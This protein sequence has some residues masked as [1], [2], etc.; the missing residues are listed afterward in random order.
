MRSI[1]YFIYIF[2][3]LTSCKR[4]HHEE[5]ISD[6]EI[7]SS[8]ENHSNTKNKNEKVEIIGLL[9]HRFGDLKY[10]STNISASLFE[11]HLKYLKENEFRVIT[12]GE[13]MNILFS[14]QSVGRYVVITID[15]GFKSFKE[16][17]YPLLKKY[18]FQATLFINTETVGSG[19]YLNWEDLALISSNGIEIG[20][21]THSHGYFLNMDQSE[22]YSNFKND[23]TL[24]Q[25]ILDERLNVQPV[26][27]AYPFGEYDSIMKQEIA[28]LGFLG[29][30]AQNSGVISHYSDS[31]ALPRFPMTEQYGNMASFIEKLSLKPLPV[32]FED[33]QTTTPIENPPILRIQLKKG[34]YNIDQMQCFIQGGSCE[35]LTIN[36]IDRIIEIS[37]GSKLKNR[38]HLYTITMPDKTGKEWYWY[39]HQWVFPDIKE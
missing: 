24:S 23:V 1:L 2:F 9:Y 25:Q 28:K 7:N 31:Y 3:F 35:Y 12:L 22:R 13:A 15:D 10:P 29:A 18:G 39:S 14:N 36:T 11:K 21:H 33:P 4:E 26:V 8:N 19:D 38:R 20:N 32:V 5:H 37:S 17:G 6:S 34:D 30:A 16:D 27:F